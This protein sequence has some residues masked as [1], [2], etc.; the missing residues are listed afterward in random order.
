MENSAVSNRLDL[1]Q[2]KISRYYHEP[3]NPQSLSNSY[4]LTIHEA[5]NGD[6]WF[7]TMQGLSRLRKEDRDQPVFTRYLMKDGLPNDVIYGILEDSPAAP[8]GSAPITVSP[9]SIP[10]HGDI[11]EFRYP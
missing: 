5:Q 9:A 10:R 1:S 4:I 3:S 8:C 6:L 11:Q 2:V 7:G